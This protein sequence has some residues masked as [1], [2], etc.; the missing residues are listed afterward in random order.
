M[1]SFFVLAFLALMCLSVPVWAQEG[2]CSLNSPDDGYTAGTCTK[3]TLL[4]GESCKWAGTVG[5]AT[6]GMAKL[7]SCSAGELTTTQEGTN[8]G[9]STGTTQTGSSSTGGDANGDGSCAV[10]SITTGFTTG[11][12]GERLANGATCQWS[13]ESGTVVEG[14]TITVG[15]ND[16]SLNV[17]SAKLGGVTVGAAS[18]TATVSMWAAGAVAIA[19]L[20]HQRM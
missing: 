18:F 5:T 11:T 19:A 2:S 13:G 14:Y 15:C 4:D 3:D 6:E 12:C 9:S 10:P 17:E 8:T 7:L 1:R 16:G 20:M